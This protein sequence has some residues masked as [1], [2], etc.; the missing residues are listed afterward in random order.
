MTEHDHEH[1]H[2]PEGPPDCGDPTCTAHMMIRVH[3]ELSTL[4]SG[5]KLRHV[6]Q[7]DVTYIAREDM[8]DLMNTLFQFQQ[9][10]IRKQANEQESLEQMLGLIEA[11]KP[12]LNGMAAMAANIKGHLNHEGSLVGPHGLVPDSVPDSWTTGNDR[13]PP[14]EPS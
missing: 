14:T 13:T 7:D 11:Y 3:Q 1:D 8:L 4:L 10:I 6:V 5:T 2:E 12:L 9:D